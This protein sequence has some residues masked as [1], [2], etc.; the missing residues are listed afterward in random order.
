M[1]SENSTQNT[2]NTP[3]QN[4]ANQQKDLGYVEKKSLLGVRSTGNI[5]IVN[6]L[7]ATQNQSF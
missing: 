2:S 6:D 3:Q 4:S 1:W 7:V 5:I